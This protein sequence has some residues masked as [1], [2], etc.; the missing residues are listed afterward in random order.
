MSASIGISTYP[1]DG[2]DAQTLQKNAD[3]AMYRAKDQGR[4]GW[5]YYSSTT[6]T[7]TLER[8]TLE[9]Q[10]RRA[11]ER[12]ELVLHYQPKQDIASGRITGMEALVRWNHPELGM[13]APDRFIPL[14]EE[15]GLIVALG[16]MGL[17]AS[18]RADARAARDGGDRAAARGGESFR[19]PI[20]G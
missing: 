1:A 16:R 14:A 9:G 7:H 5:H 20:L 6:D 12:E 13:I 10:L 17:A 8:L 15:T 11:L 18:V 4:S 2:N 3:I 19:A